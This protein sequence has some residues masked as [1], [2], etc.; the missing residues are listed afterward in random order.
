MKAGERRAARAGAASRGRVSASALGCVI[1]SLYL[2]EGEARAEYGGRHADI[3]RPRLGLN[4]GYRSD[5]ET[6]RDSL[7]TRA[8]SSHELS[9][10][11]EIETGGWL[12]HPALATY[13]LELAPQWQQSGDASD[14]GPGIGSH[15]F[16]LGYEL[17]L[18]LF[19]YK[20]YTLDLTA[21]QQR[22]VLTASLASPSKSVS[23][24]LRAT[25]RLKYRL[26]PTTL[27]LSHSKSEQTG[28]YDSREN[29]DE[30]LLNM[31]H[32]AKTND[33]QFNVSAI[34]MERAVVGPAVHT[35]NVFG[36]LRN[37]WELTA[38]KSM[39]LNS[40]LT[41]RWSRNDLQRASGVSLSESL[42]WKH[43]NRLSSTYNIIHSSESTEGVRVE[44]SSLRA[45]L[46]HSLYENL[47]SSVSASA[48]TGSQGQSSYGGQLGFSY[49]R[50]IPG[51]MIYAS[52]GS[53]YRVTKRSFGSTYQAVIG[54][55]HALNDA[56]VTLLDNR[57][58]DLSSVRVTS[59][60]GSITYVEGID[61]TLALIG[62]SLRIS[63]SPFGAIGPGQTVRIDYSWLADPA[64]DDATRSDSYGLG[65]YL[66]SAWRINYR[67]GQSRQEFLA[68][69]RPDVL[70][71]SSGHT[72]ESD[73]EVKWSHTRLLYEDTRSSV[74]T[75]MKRWRVEES[76]RFQPS[77]RVFLGASVY[78]GR[79]A[80]RDVDASESFHGLRADLQ[81]LLSRGSRLRFEAAYGVNRGG[82]IDTVDR[83]LSAA[84]EWSYAVWRMDASYRYLRQEDVLS[85]Q[86]RER[87]SIFFTVRRSL[88]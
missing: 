88:F 79:T 14:G 61:Y 77:D 76:V 48:S 43:T 45:G 38:D 22:S 47:L 33:T 80:W 63:R 30:L 10:G 37:R 15:S 8:T 83:G 7:G 6:R 32:D 46:T 55:S 53:D 3:E 9:E 66:W 11:F 12:Y 81:W 19:P 31:R 52:I 29:R 2:L 58:V 51:G 18:N 41:Y 35:Q 65:F 56:E 44:N 82:S 84:W 16:F 85:G 54:E 27:S 4:L 86:G 74:G 23:E 28:F 69:T 87:H 34:T 62:S 78:Y 36:N 13:T 57:Q 42:N 50:R 75:S 17:G 5:R 39:L 60:D 71:Q 40:G 72:L 68:G 64:F 1:L 73:L 25:L 24:S 70:A 20:P 49:Q 21:R 67:Y 59:L 26:V